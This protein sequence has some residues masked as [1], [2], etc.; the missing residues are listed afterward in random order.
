MFQEVKYFYLRPVI[1]KGLFNST[2][3]CDAFTSFL[4]LILYMNFLYRTLKV[5][6]T[7]STSTYINT[8]FNAT[9]RI[10]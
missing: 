10:S 5:F 7:L 6:L 1:D 4:D 9:Q 3:T 2:F 8:H